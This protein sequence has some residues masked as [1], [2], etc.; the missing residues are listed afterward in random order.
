MFIIGRQKGGDEYEMEKAVIYTVLVAYDEPFMAVSDC[1]ASIAYGQAFVSGS[2]AV[3]L[4]FAGLHAL[5]PN[6]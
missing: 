2:R 1:I 4:G 5:Y 6:R 3:V